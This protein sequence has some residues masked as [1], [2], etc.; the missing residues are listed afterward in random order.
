MFKSDAEYSEAV[1]FVE[2]NRVNREMLYSEFEAVLDGVV[3]IPDLAGRSAQAVYLR[4]NGKLQIIAAVF[5]RISF[6]S[7]GQADKRWNVPIEQFADNS[8]RGPDLG[9]GPIRLAC[10]S[11]CSIAWHQQ[12]LWDPDMTPGNNDFILLKKAIKANRLNL[13][14]QAPAETE[15]PPTL[16]KPEKSAAPSK[17]D[18]REIEARLSQQLRRKFEQEFR[19]HMAG[20][21]KEQR[22]RILTLNSKR[23]QEVQQLQLNHQQRLQ[24]YRQQL[25]KRQQELEL[26]RRRNKELKE[27][28]EGQA[29]KI[30]G[31][32]EYFEHKLK[33]AHLDESTQLRTMRENFE[34]E[35][36][37][38]VA[39]ATLEIKEKLQLREVELMYRGEQE[40]SL[41]REIRRLREENQHLLNNSNGQLLEKLEQAGV[42]FVAY[43]PGAGHL[44]VPL[45]DMAAYLEDPTGYA[46]AKC[47]VSTHQYKD[48]LDHYRQPKCRAIKDGGEVC[49]ET[50][51]R[52][53]SPGQFHAGEHDRCERHRSAPARA[54][55]TFGKNAAV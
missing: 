5:F 39:A 21:L 37:A 36:Q 31:L 19:D 35:V 20:L 9:G 28:I 26:Q 18:T 3:P 49:A 33:S 54:Y 55:A 7:D 4:V 1:L 32:R 50:I 25:D 24:E 13:R 48:W 43:H 16:A 23:Q 22:L 15:E 46:A 44:T 41:E 10:R 45:A 30:E 40:A 53:P 8:G 6:D 11:Q 12:N 38:K 17:A 34:T 42:N 52:V 2:H 47:G 27:T 51:D 14:V 29:K